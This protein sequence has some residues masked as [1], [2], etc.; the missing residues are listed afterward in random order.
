ML[1]GS[2]GQRVKLYTNLF[3]F[4]LTANTRFHQY[5]ITYTPT[6]E[7]T[8]LKRKLIRTLEEH[9]DMK[10]RYVTDGSSLFTTAR[11]NEEVSYFLVGKYRRNY[12]F[13]SNSQLLTNMSATL[14]SSVYRVDM[15]HVSTIQ[16]NSGHVIQILNIVFG[17]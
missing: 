5:A 2:Q 4:E 8:R 10:S 13:I 12:T 11:F 6:V 16:P 9:L 17:R 1:S 15:K 14:G 7:S 3:N